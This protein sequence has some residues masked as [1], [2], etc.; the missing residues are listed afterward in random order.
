MENICVEFLPPWIETGLKPAFYDKESGHVLQ[1]TARMYARVNMLIR[2][3]NKLSKNTKTTVEDY[4]NQFNEL[5]DYV[6]DY[7]DNLDVQEE[8]N[9]K[10]DEMDENGRLQE[11]VDVYLAQYT[12]EWTEFEKLMN[13][14]N[15]EYTTNYDNEAETTYYL[16]NI[17]YDNPYGGNNIIR[18]GLANDDTTISGVE[19][20]TEFAYRHESPVVT[21]AGIFYSN[22][23]NPTA[24]GLVIKDGIVL[25]NEN[26][27]T[28][29]YRDIIAIKENGDMKSYPVG[30]NPQVII[31]DGYVDA[32]VGYYVLIEN[33]EPVDYTG[34]ADSGVNP[35]QIVC[36]KT[37][38]DYLFL[39]CDGRTENDKGLDLDD[40]VRIL[41]TQDVDFAFVLDGGGSTNTIVKGSKINKFIDG[42]GTRERA[43]ATMLYVNSTTSELYTMIG[44]VHNDNMT[45][46]ASL[47]V[48]FRQIAN[49]GTS[50]SGN[51]FN[52][53]DPN[54]LTNKYVSNGE[55]VDYT[56]SSGVEGYDVMLSDYIQIP[57]GQPFYVVSAGMAE[58]DFAVVY[59]YDE[60]KNWVYT[61]NYSTIQDHVMIPSIDLAY[62]RVPVRKFRMSTFGIYVGDTYSD[63]FEEYRGLEPITLLENTA[64]VTSATL[65][66][67]QRFR[68]LKIFAT[69]SSSQQ[70]YS[71]IITNT[72]GNSLWVPFTRIHETDSTSANIYTSRVTIV[73]DTG[74]MSIDREYDIRL[75]PTPSIT[76]ST[77]SRLKITKVEGY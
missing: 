37:N 67:V 2:M 29:Y 7:F 3:F 61:F 72:S 76:L 46:Q 5:H 77:A 55:I 18:V 35:R 27:P 44:K 19:K 51:L 28:D 50:F 47:S 59:A 36:R 54:F 60:N 42:Y 22:A 68:K 62:I 57:A 48:K 56:N 53:N 8:V 73:K 38:G 9:N 21:N 52:R 24:Y 16:T 33:G 75:Q 11:M 32:I 41:A 71:E 26:V 34:Y 39:T 14:K 6:H 20:P 65:G 13:W 25:K 43:V 30:T 1:Q 15:I 23:A 31:N 49:M 17:P 74:V 12:E 63:H 58:N 69:D 45:E 66:N 64:G 70:T 4:I 10:L 40:A